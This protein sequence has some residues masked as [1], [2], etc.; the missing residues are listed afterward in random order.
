MGFATA[1][2]STPGAG[3]TSALPQTG[4]LV[5]FP[6]FSSLVW[7]RLPQRQVI[8]IIT[9]SNLGPDR[10]IGCVEWMH[11]NGDRPVPDRGMSKVAVP[12]DF[13]PFD[14]PVSDKGL[15][16]YQNRRGPG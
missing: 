14:I 2:S 7:N 4:H 10:Q 16:P 5:F 15:L 8:V 11:R 9:T 12:G 1:P 3:T 6:A 13:L